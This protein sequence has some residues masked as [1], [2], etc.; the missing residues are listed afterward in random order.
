MEKWTNR[1]RNAN[2]NIN[3]RENFPR[4]LWMHVCYVQ[5]A[6]II[7]LDRKKNRFQFNHAFLFG[8]R[9]ETWTLFSVF[10][11][12]SRQLVLKMRR[13]TLILAIESNQTLVLS[14]TVVSCFEFV[15][16]KQKSQKMG[17]EQ[18]FIFFSL[19]SSTLNQTA[20]S[21]FA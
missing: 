12:C 4:N 20:F 8:E 6:L 16:R 19:M 13:I 7:L 18:N 5:G 15:E 11:I 2:R 10:V 21:T 17:K 3:G 14:V 9:R 1:N